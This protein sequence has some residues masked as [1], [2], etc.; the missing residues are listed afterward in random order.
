M[1]LAERKEL[2]SNQPKTAGHKAGQVQQSQDGLTR[3]K[4]KE[5]EDLVVVLGTVLE[6]RLMR[7]KLNRRREWS[8]SPVPPVPGLLLRRYGVSAFVTTSDGI[9]SR[10]GI[11]LGETFPDSVPVPPESA[12]VGEAVS[13]ARLGVARV[14]VIG[15]EPRDWSPPVGKLVARTLSSTS[16]ELGNDPWMLLTRAFT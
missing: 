11:L 1:A 13:V 12:G 14:G 15:A 4:N 7:A 3:D 10:W 9:R 2:Q 16:M 5:R 8:P 6:W